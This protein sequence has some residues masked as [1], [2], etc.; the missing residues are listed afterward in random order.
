MSNISPQSGATNPSTL[1][2]ASYEK[3]Q[4]FLEEAKKPG[5][6]VNL[7]TSSALKDTVWPR[8]SPDEFLLEPGRLCHRTRLHRFLALDHLDSGKAALLRDGAAPSECIRS[9]EKS[10]S[11]LLDAPA[12]V[13]G[14]RNPDSIDAE[15]NRNLRA[16]WDRLESSSVVVPSCAV[17]ELRNE[18]AG[19]SVSIAWREWPDTSVFADPEVVWELAKRSITWVWS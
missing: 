16:E 9:R 7:L 2:L 6:R 15:I 5:C 1:C 10:E 14:A 12:W 8:E 19:P 17:P 4:R 11:P 3:G 18:Y 13:G